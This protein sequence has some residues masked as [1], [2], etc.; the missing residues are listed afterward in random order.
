M[1]MGTRTGISMLIGAVI[2]WAILG[3]V[4]HN[5]N[6]APGPV[7]NWET[8]AKGYNSQEFPIVIV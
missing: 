4:A 5:M 2:G 3:P 8:G 7:N 6:W 1:I